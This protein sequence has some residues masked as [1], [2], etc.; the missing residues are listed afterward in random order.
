MKFGQFVAQQML[1]TLSSSAA[2]GLVLAILVLATG[3]AEGSITLDIDISSIDSIWFLLGVPAVTC[4]LFLL[5]S[6]LSFVLH[7][8]VARVLTG[9]S[10]HDT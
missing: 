9:N 7:I 3:G 10:A 5:F 4:F 8:A 1:F 2:V 6:P